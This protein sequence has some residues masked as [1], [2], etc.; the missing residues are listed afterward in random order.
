MDRPIENRGEQLGPPSSPDHAPDH[1]LERVRTVSTLLD[2]AVRVPGTNLRFGLDPLLSLLPWVGDVASAAVSLYIVAEAVRMGAPAS[3]L[4]R[5]VLLVAVDVVLGSIPL[6]GPL[7][8]AVWKANSWNV[9][10]LES[11]VERTH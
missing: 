3:L 1:A 7:F 10:M 5:M 11:H 9:S 8:D 2:D 4:L 6:I